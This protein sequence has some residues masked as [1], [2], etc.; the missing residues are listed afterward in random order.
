MNNSVDKASY[1]NN[2]GLIQKLRN[3]YCKYR[4]F[5]GRLGGDKCQAACGIC[6]N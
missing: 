2:R 4:F 6:T 3:I 5:G 1:R